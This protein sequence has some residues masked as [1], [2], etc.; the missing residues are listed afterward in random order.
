METN[1]TMEQ[2]KEQTPK[3]E[4][5][6]ESLVTIENFLS[7]IDVFPTAISEEQLEAAREKSQQNLFGSSEIFCLDERVAKNYD[8]SFI[9]NDQA[10]KQCEQGKIQFTM[11]L[12]DEAVISFTKAITLNPQMKEFYV[13]RAEVYLHTGDFQSSIINYKKASA[14]DPSDEDLVS[15][16]AHT[17]YIQGQYL[18]DAKMYVAALEVFAQASDLRPEKQHYYMR[19]IATL[20][21]LGRL[22]DCLHLVNNQLEFV[23]SNPDLYILRARLYDHF[24][25]IANCYRDVRTVL[26]LDPS[27]QEAVSLM[28]TLAQRAE[29]AKAQAVNKALKGKLN[30]ALIK[31]N[32]AID[33]NPNKADYYVFRGILNRRLRNFNRAIDDYLFVLD[34]ISDTEQSVTYQE[35]RGQLLLT[36]NDFAVHCYHKEFFEEAILLLNLSIRGEKRQKGLYIN[37]GDCFLKQCLLD[38]ALLDYEQAQEL[39]PEDWRIQI[40]IAAINNQKGLIEYENR[41]YEQ[42]EKQF[43]S[44]IESNPNVSHYYLHRAKTREI[45]QHMTGSQEDAIMSLLLDIR[46]KQIIPLLTHL[47]P[48]KSIDEIMGSQVVESARTK[49][50]ASLHACTPCVMKRLQQ[51]QPSLMQPKHPSNGISGTDKVAPEAESGF[52]PCINEKDLYEEIVAKKKM[53]TQEIKRSLH[54]RK[55]LLVDRPRISMVFQPADIASRNSEDASQS[56][57]SNWKKI[58][59]LLTSVT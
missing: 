25:Q 47:F 11:G 52:A 58:C 30:G 20:V 55:P 1:A 5:M 22:E 14:L 19:S 32:V 34:S 10:N 17:M 24:F 38:F 9:I 3:E 4:N 37:R 8:I 41:N 36:Y 43:T 51:R 40:R 31:I 59:S 33:N 12:L 54:R 44:A 57:Q 45:L 7:E 39:D 42:A 15:Q 49:L 6:S 28:A 29:E 23:T 56:Q 2:A 50:K 53:I 46:N 16:I 26:D 18:F 13:R 21:A 48:G 27:N 35:T